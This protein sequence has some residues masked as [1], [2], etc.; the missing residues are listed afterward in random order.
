MSSAEAQIATRHS[1]VIPPVEAQAA[2]TQHFDPTQPEKAMTSYQKLMH[3]H[4]LQQFENANLSS[5]R[6][7]SDKDMGVASLPSEGSRGS[8]SSTG[9]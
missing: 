5:R 9:S 3:Q 8:M 2:F 7:S 6:R 4:T 1:E